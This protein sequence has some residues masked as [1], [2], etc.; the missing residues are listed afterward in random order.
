MTGHLHLHTPGVT[1]WQDTGRPHHRHL[2]VPTSGPL[3]QQR[4]RALHNLLPTPQPVW[5]NLTGDL[6][7]TVH[8]PAGQH[9][10]AALTGPASLH[11]PHHLA[12]PANTTVLLPAGDYEMRRHGTGP[13]YLALHTWQPPEPILGSVSTDTHSRLGP[14]PLAPGDTIPLTATTHTHHAGAFTLPARSHATPTL[15]MYP[16]WREG[17]AYLT[18]TTWTVQSYARNGI[19]LTPQPTAPQPTTAPAHESIVSFPVLPGVIQLPPDGN[20]IVLG[21]DSG[22]SGGYPTIGWIPPRDFDAL[23]DATPTTPLTFAVQ[24]WDTLTGRDQENRDHLE[25][26][27]AVQICAITDQASVWP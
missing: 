26:A 11:T 20:P 23:T 24:D 12:T 8:L 14:P 3:H 7:F 13:V 27:P 5:E 19:R 22:T 25:P 10:L 1:T 15:T 9:V 6:H 18:G 21:P 2:G 17:A 4:F 16:H